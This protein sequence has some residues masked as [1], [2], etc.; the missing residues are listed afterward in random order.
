MPHPL[1][2]VVFFFLFGMVA[3]AHHSTAQSLDTL[4]H[5]VDTLNNKI[6]S[7]NN[8]I[9]ENVVKLTQPKIGLPDS[10]KALNNLD[11]LKQRVGHKTDSIKGRINHKVDSLEN[12]IN[13]VGDKLN[14]IQQKAN[15]VPGLDVKG[16]DVPKVD[17]NPDLKTPGLNTPDINAPNLN[18][19]NL[20]TPDLKTPDINSI[21]QLDQLNQIKEDAGKIQSIEG[22]VKDLPKTIDT[23][24]EN[25]AMQIDE[26]KDLQKQTGEM[27]KAQ[28][29]INANNPE[30][31]KEQAQQQFQQQAVD[32][33][34]GKEEALKSAM[35]KL[36]KLKQKYT[37]V[38]SIKDLP[39]RPPNPMKGKPLI[40]RIVPG[41][42]LQINNTRQAFMIDI[43]PVVSYRFTGR[44]NAGLGW[45]ERVAFTKWNR[46][47][48]YDRIYG[49]RVFGSFGFKKGFSAKAEI[50]K[51]NTI[52]PVSPTSQDGSRVW[53]W[54]AFVGL[55]K[56]YKFMGKVKGNVQMLYNLWDDHDNSPYFD[57]FNVRMGFEFPMKTPKKPAGK[58]KK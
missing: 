53:V 13:S 7:I 23:K 55:K 39:K 22:E 58:A 35:D 57:R 31:F 6:N 19:P 9:N 27:G 41:V 50:E 3:F 25:K 8:R 44:I 12:K 38:S 46:I 40:E 32:H 5:K 43:N 52:V 36:S 29:L 11:S 14:S 34:K 54:S 2:I 15:D 18:A 26:V 24:I 42:T 1:K 56:D 21:N 16:I 37:E 10:I 51:M 47:S 20:K 45:N 17:L 4:N 49:P 48:S 30:A 33:F 28:E